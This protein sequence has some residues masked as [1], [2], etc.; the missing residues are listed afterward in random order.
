MARGR[1]SDLICPVTLADIKL[2]ICIR[3]SGMGTRAPLTLKPF[4]SSPSAASRLR[5]QSKLCDWHGHSSWSDRASDDRDL[6]H[7]R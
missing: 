5:S 4:L 2:H 3:Q 1:D 7:C 6:V